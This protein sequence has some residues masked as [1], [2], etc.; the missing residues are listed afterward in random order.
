MHAVT[1]CIVVLVA[2]AAVSGFAYGRHVTNH[3]T[4]SAPSHAVTPANPVM[5]TP[6]A[7]SVPSG[8]T[9]AID[10]YETQNGPGVG[11]WVIGSSQVAKAN[12]MYVF[13]RIGPAKGF[14]N[15][16]QGGYGFALDSG[17]SRSVIGFGSAMVGC[18]GSNSPVA[19]SAV[20]AEFGFACPPN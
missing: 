12:P 15:S 18:S 13:F 5:P 8:A 10:H 11:K 7:S 6:D 14:E 17:S 20:L 3:V 1:A 2:V 4:P 19:P 9:A 16:V